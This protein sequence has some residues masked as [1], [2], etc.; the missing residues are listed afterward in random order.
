MGLQLCN[1][2]VNDNVRPGSLTSKSIRQEVLPHA[3]QVRMKVCVPS[4]I[5]TSGDI[6]DIIS[7]T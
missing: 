3:M 4:L 1:S 6:S 5:C 2:S 7:V